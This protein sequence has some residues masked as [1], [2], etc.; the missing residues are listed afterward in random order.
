MHKI[1]NR[2]S[3]LWGKSSADHDWLPLVCHMVDTA[4][5]AMAILH[6]EPL[7][8]TQLFAGD[9]ATN[10]ES[11]LAWV[12]GLVGLHDIGKATP[13]F[14]SQWTEGRLRVENA[15]LPIPATVLNVHHGILGQKILLELLPRQGWNQSVATS[16]ADALGAHHGIRAVPQ[17]LY[18][19][20]RK[21][22]G[23]DQAWVSVR[24]ELLQ[25]IC[26]IVHVAS[27]PGIETLSGEG[28]MRLAGLTSFADWIA[29][30]EDFFPHHSEV[31]DI[32]AYYSRSL[33]LADAALDH[34]GW[35]PRVPLG[36][37]QLS[38]KHVFGFEPR[39]LQ[40]AV[41]T[42]MNDISTP[43]LLLIESPMGEGKTEAAFYADL[44]LQLSAKHRGMYIALPTQ[45][46]G[47]A[48]FE[49][50]HAFL[51]SVLDSEE[52][53]ILD[54]QLVHGAA[55]LNERFT[56]MQLAGIGERG[57]Q[58]REKVVAHEWFTSK[59]RALLSAYGVGTI[60]Q[61][62]LSILDVRHQFVRLWG[63][64]NRTIVIDEVH[65]YDIYT[66]KLIDHLLRWLRALGSSVILLSATLPRKRREALISSFGGS[67][68]TASPRYPRIT[69]VTNGETRMQ[70]VESSRT[71]KMH[72][73]SAPKALPELAHFLLDLVAGGGAACCIVNTVNRAQF[74][75]RELTK[76]RGSS[77]TPRLGIFHARYPADQRR[78]I[79]GS[80]LAQYGPH[81][82]RGLESSILVA[83]Q[84]VEQSLDVDFDVMVTDL[85]PIDL[86]LQRSGRMH[87]H[88]S[89]KRPPALTQ[90][91]LY[92]TGQASGDEPPDL[93]PERYVYDEYI[94][95][96]SW[97]VLRETA[98]V[99]IPEDFDGL[100]AGV[101][102]QRHSVKNASAQLQKSL[103]K[104]QRQFEENQQEDE[105]LAQQAAIADPA[106]YLDQLP[107]DVRVWDDDDPA[108][109][110]MLLAKTRLGHPSLLAIPI[111]KTGS[112]YSLYPNGK[113]P[114]NFE[115]SPTW[116]EGREM[117]LRGISISRPGVYHTLR[118]VRLPN[119]WAKHPLL[120]NTR[121]L[122]LEGDR[123]TIGDVTV[124]LDPILGLIFEDAKRKEKK[125]Q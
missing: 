24:E 29:S 20:M 19:P 61:A 125:R 110:P 44:S 17:E 37:R 38:F 101:Y 13:A 111:H 25:V 115:M 27:P 16:I 22:L 69:C 113:H 95:L 54:L 108:T 100:I 58:E 31:G 28:F 103:Q 109:H 105:L 123:T 88:L 74:L 76:A 9:L 89:R 67:S 3:V 91:T 43:I 21:S 112:A 64:G 56:Q 35:H 90:P 11:A 49:R 68:T 7:S 87:R 92:V 83:T 42:L 51:E 122:V 104:A 41:G 102:S 30:N 85:A 78:R 120:R 47:N 10:N 121:P 46:T 93:D 80:V 48:M 12:S 98:T 66:S 99:S 77:L 114:L 23:T 8:T 5:V 45:A 116:H 86:I 97:A 65:A 32:D 63:L 34:I 4:A 26:N 79:E 75:F 39:P 106:D 117:Y 1:S 71:S 94:L 57:E 2:A 107:P 62:L 59:K 81:S 96:R 15:Q 124:T 40:T 72:I 70:H 53:A 33:R 118:R 119:G 52:E 60:D 84:V 18:R 73:R 36:N 6:R 55:L 14:Q 50:T 82:A